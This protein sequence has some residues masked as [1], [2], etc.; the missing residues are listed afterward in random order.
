LI[1]FVLIYRP[2]RIRHDAVGD[3]IHA[4]LSSIVDLAM[5][6]PTM[7]TTVGTSSTI[8]LIITIVIAT[9]TTITATTHP[10]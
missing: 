1:G 7:D 10:A 3:V 2:C 9:I 5:F 4:A 8:A 6:A